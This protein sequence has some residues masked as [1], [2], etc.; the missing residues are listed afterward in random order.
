MDFH[1]Q[2]IPA[3]ERAHRY[4]SALLAYLE[5]FDARVRFERP[6]PAEQFAASLRTVDLGEL[7]GAVHTINAAHTVEALP[8]LGSPARPDSVDWYL[9][10]DGELLMSTPQARAQLKRGDMMLLR[11]SDGFHGTSTGVDLTV[12]TV[13]GYLAQGARSGI[14][15]PI[16]GRSG[17]ASGVCAL[18]RTALALPAQLSIEEALF[19]EVSVAHAFALISAAGTQRDRQLEQIKRLVLQNLQNSDLCAAS[20]AREAGIST[21]QLQRLFERS[22]TTFSDWVRD[23][24]I[25]RCHRDLLASVGSARPCIARIAFKWGFN[26]LRTFNRAFR[27]RYGMTPREAARRPLYARSACPPHG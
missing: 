8:R 15:Q 19:I 11:S 5:G 10:N 17:F 14:G 1:S 25:E 21:R 18:I 13:P 20:I 22:G 9:V 2:Q 7:T 27:L 26:D 4:E 12:I 23:R 24:R 3:A 16:A 6:L